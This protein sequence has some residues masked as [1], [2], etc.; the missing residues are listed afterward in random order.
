MTI[1]MTASSLRSEAE[2][3]PCRRED[4]E[5]FFAESPADLE[6]AKTLCH[7]C[8]VRAECLAG[9][10]ERREPWGVWGRRDLPAGSGDPSQAAPWPAPEAPRRR[11]RRRIRPTT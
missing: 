2:T 6:L 3:L 1:D 5:L 11:R 7:T 10:L 8:P 4:A 9:A